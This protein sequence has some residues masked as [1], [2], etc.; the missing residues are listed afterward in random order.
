MEASEGC[1]IEEWGDGG[2]DPFGNVDIGNEDMLMDEEGD[3]EE[4][5]EEDAGRQHHSEEEV[6]DP[7]SVERPETRWCGDETF[8]DWG[9]TDKPAPIQ[10]QQQYQ[11][12]KEESKRESGGGDDRGTQVDATVGNE[13]DE[14]ESGTVVSEQDDWGFSS[15]PFA[16]KPTPP[17]KVQNISE[18]SGSERKKDGFEE[19][20]F[21]DVDWHD[22]GSEMG[23]DENDEW[24]DGLGAEDWHGAES[25]EG[26]GK[27]KEW[28]AAGSEWNDG[29]WQT[30]A[31]SS[32]PPTIP[33]LPMV[34]SVLEE[35]TVALEANVQSAVQLVLYRVKK[36][37]PHPRSSAPQGQKDVA[38]P[39][40]KE[41]LSMSHLS[42]YGMHQLG[43]SSATLSNLRTSLGIPEGFELLSMP[44]EFLPGG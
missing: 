5:D 25:G 44:A 32:M 26:G 9:F 43:A 41:P 20:P 10:E 30:E 23:K 33:E 12:R 15:S 3:R 24:A 22:G 13:G 1:E 36:A 27:S 19:D 21:E 11:E 37:A 8:E 42:V 29:G 7:W 17:P 16:P 35:D 14:W 6:A 40:I 2:F 18:I 38:Q 31:S 34:E 28:D 39:K 4:E